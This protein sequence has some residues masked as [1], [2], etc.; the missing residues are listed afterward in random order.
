MIFN[1]QEL[2]EKILDFENLL[3]DILFKSPKR[4]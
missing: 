1:H 4:L 2:K 3:G